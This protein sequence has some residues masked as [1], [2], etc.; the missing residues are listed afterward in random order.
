MY[1]LESVCYS[2]LCS[3]MH[4]PQSRLPSTTFE[5]QE[6]LRQ[7]GWNIEHTQMKS[8][9]KNFVTALAG[10]LCCI[11]FNAE[12]LLEGIVSRSVDE[13]VTGAVLHV[14]ELYASLGGLCSGSCSLAW[15]GRRSTLGVRSSQAARSLFRVFFAHAPRQACGCLL[16]ARCMCVSLVPMPWFGG[17]VKLVTRLVGVSSVTMNWFWRQ[18]MPQAPLCS[19]ALT[20]L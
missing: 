5:D 10:L 15:P 13:R 12:E 1:L 9:L 16:L 19:R 6:S 18:L 20:A 8:T 17:L 7:R 14:R 2:L 4:A 11:Q 3:S